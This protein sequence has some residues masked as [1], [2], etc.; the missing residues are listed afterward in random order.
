MRFGGGRVTMVNV[1]GKRGFLMGVP[2]FLDEALQ[3]PRGSLAHAADGEDTFDA[4]LEARA[5]RE[6]LIIDLRGKGGDVK[7]LRR[8]YPIGLS[9]AAA[10]SILKDMKRAL[11]YFTKRVRVIAAVTGSLIGVGILAGWFLTPL[12]AVLTRNMPIALGALADG[13]MFALALGFGW[14]LLSKAVQIAL[15]RRFPH[16][17][18]H[19]TMR[20]P[21]GPV[22]YTMLTFTALAGIAT[23]FLA[24][25]RPVWLET[26]LAMFGHH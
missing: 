21:I 22:G 8:L 25:L 6:A 16:L 5:I 15:R 2:P 17:H 18:M 14:V 13:L 7:E 19:I 9:P 4:A 26:L 20:R 10:A 24:P 3:S 12:N 11:T 23:M 1:F